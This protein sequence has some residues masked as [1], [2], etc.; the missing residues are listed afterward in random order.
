MSQVVQSPLVQHVRER[1]FADLLV[2][3]HAIA[4]ADR[5]AAQE[6]HVGFALCF[7]MIELGLEIGIAISIKPHLSVVRLQVGPILGQEAVQSIAVAVASECERCAN[8]S[9]IENRSGGGFQRASASEISLIR[10]RRIPGVACSR[11]RQ[12]SAL[13]II[14]SSY[15]AAAP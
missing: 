3:R 14:L 15:V 13:T 1:D 5:Q 4:G 6:F 2:H 8:T 11:S 7:E 10:L 9:A 12:G